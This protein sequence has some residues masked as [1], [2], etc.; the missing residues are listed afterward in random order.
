MTKIAESREFDLKHILNNDAINEIKL[1][2]ND[3]GRNIDLVSEETN[4]QINAMS[5]LMNLI[6]NSIPKMDKGSQVL[7]LRIRKR[8]K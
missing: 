7:K 5:R 1:Y 4:N 2:F 6:D 3:L 8:R